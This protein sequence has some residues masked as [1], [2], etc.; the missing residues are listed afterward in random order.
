MKKEDLAFMIKEGVEKAPTPPN[1]RSWKALFT[2]FGPGAIIASLTI[3]SGEL[4]WTPRAAAAF[5]YV[6]IW[7]FFYGVWVKCVIQWLANRWHVLTGESASLATKRVIGVWFNVFM[8]ACILAVMPMWMNILSSLSAMTAWTAVGKPGS[9]HPFWIAIVVL[10]LILLV[11]SAKIGK[12]YAV[13]EKISQALLWLMFIFLWLAVIIGTRPDWGAFV[14]NLFIPRAIPPYEPWIEKA[15]PDIWS[16]TP[17]MLL[18]TALGALG[19]GIQDYVGYQAML[20]ERGWGI[21]SYERYGEFVKIYHELGRI[22]TPLPEDSDSISKIRQWLK[23]PAYDTFLSFFMV[24]IVTTPA[25]ILTIEVLRPLKMAPSGLALVT[26]Q[27]KWLTETIHPTLGVIW[28]IGAFFAFWGT[29]YA[30][31]EVYN[32]TVYDML[33]CSFKRL[34]DVSINKVRLYLWT[35][36][37]IVGAIFYATGF[38]LPI[39]AAFASAATHLFAL[40]IWGIGLLILNLFYVPKAYRVNPIIAILVVIGSIVYFIYGIITLIQVFVPFKI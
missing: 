40:S 8:L 26:A 17:F 30:L 38:S 22:K 34:A 2:I 20:K 39:L 24:F 10:T 1:L 19:G 31:W 4:V 14:S 29:Y 15:A 32:W 25:V 36:I 28:W 6:M 5:G 27:V 13:V 23:V 7:A 3:G 11:Y 16:L 21:L 33:R 18:G 37:L 9:V 35:Y 12:A